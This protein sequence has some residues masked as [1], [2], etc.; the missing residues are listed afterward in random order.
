M[1]NFTFNTGR[2]YGANGQIIECRTVQVEADD[3]L[4][5]VWA[6]VEFDDVTR[7]IRGRVVLYVYE[8]T[9]HAIEAGLLAAYD[10]D[11]YVLI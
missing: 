8:M 3:I 10:R 7:G 4:E 1:I 6:T 11:Q 2:A 9:Q 5:G